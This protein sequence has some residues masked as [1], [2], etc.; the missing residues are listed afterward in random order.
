M[1]N[2]SRNIYLL[3]NTVIFTIGN[4]GSKLIS[5]FLI[6]LYTNVLT[7]SQYGTVD[8]ITTISTVAAPVLTMNIAE[9]VMRFGLDKNANRDKITQCGSLTFFASV[10]IGLIVI[11]ICRYIPAISSYTLYVYFYIISLA[12][13]Q[14]YLCDL[15]GK[16]L[17]LQ[18][19]LGNILQTFTIAILNIIFL[20]VLNMGT[21][22]YLLAYILSNFLVALYAVIIGKGYKSFNFSG[23]D[24]NMFNGMIKYSIVLIPNTF[25]WWIMNSSDRVMVSYF[26]GTAANGIYAV[27]YKLPTL[28]STF[29]GIFNQAWGYSA[30]REEGKSDEIEYNNK[31]FRT[32]T[33]TATL[34]GLGMLLT[35]KPFLRFYVSPSYYQAWKYTPFLIV[36]C[37]F[38]TLA[39]FMSTSYTVHKDSFG[40]LFSGMFGA[41]L[42]IILNYFLIPHI[43]VYGAALATCLSYISVFFFRL[44]H[45]QK[46]MRYN[47]LYKKFAI[48]VVLLLLSS[49][50]IFVDNIIGLIL[51]TIIFLIGLFMYNEIWNPIVRK[52]IFRNKK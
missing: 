26:I 46:Y 32:L 49:I 7:T 15:R 10:L 28:V 24:K 17:L 20:L 27:S 21:Q 30:I 36:G 1:Q 2:E 50:F 9:S 34:M 18:Y 38:L 3:K 33:A 39:T 6:P 5:F 25:M 35:I 48:G 14:L 4:L 13:S 51:Q 42:N 19:S 23:F 45:T 43:G 41:F 44:F 12:A 52:F 8:L 16:E 37:V 11:P 22:G 47:I 40:Y 29:T 31:I